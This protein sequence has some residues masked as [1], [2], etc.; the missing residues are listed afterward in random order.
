MAVRH[1]GQTPSMAPPADLKKEPV[2]R[3]MYMGIPYAEAKLYRN[4]WY[5]ETVDGYKAFVLQGR[6]RR[7]SDPQRGPW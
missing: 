3:V 1:I 7:V 4:I 5:H 2:Y 6:V